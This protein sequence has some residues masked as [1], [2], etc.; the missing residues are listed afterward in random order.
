M[1][2]CL[3][4]LGENLGNLSAATLS[5]NVGM[6]SGLEVLCC[7]NLCRSLATSLDLTLIFCID[8]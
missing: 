5:M 6:L 7:F 1:L 4:Y 2:G 8:G 3:K